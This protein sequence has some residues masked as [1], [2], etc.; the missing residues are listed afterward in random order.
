MVL[1]YNGSVRVFLLL[2][3]AAAGQAGEPPSDIARRVAERETASEAERANYLYRQSLTV[4]EFL[5]RGTRTGEYREVRE[6]I[7]SPS[8]ERSERLAEPPVNTLKRL[9][10]TEEDFRDV[11][12]IQPLLLTTDR[13]FLYQVTPKGEETI[14]GVACWVLQVRP[15]QILS[16]QRLFEGMFWID[17]R[18][19]S[20]LRSEGRAVPQIRSTRP[21]KEN[22]FPY[23]TT[24]REKVGEF[25]FPV[26]THADDTLDFSSGPLRIRM[27]IR[28][29]DY[30][31]F[32]AESK[33][34]EETA[35]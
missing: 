25:R 31:R 22:L 14:D 1:R 3:V 34:V 8:G 26:H 27:T 4:E 33:I 16:G 32:G 2:L 28:Y 12:E 9:R 20:I 18:D 23:F 7:F 35:P 30:K 29:M 11:R 24:I 21:G 17:Q 10:L 15:R 5:A 13:L 19:F 6:I